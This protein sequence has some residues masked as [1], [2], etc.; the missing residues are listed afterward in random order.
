MSIHSQP[1]ATRIDHLTSKERM[2]KALRGEP[3]DV[4]PVAPAYPSLFLADFERAYYAEQY[5]LR[6]RG[7]AQLPGAV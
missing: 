6:L 5:R 1:V 4:Y 3:I 2:V 7:R